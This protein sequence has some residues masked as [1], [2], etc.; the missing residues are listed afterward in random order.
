MATLRRSAIQPF[1]E[2]VGRASRQMKLMREGVRWK[3]ADLR[4]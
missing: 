3:Y 4:T 2:N 1:R